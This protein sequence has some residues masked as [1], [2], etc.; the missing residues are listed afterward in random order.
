MAISRIAIK[1]P[2][3]DTPTIALNSTGTYVLSV[4][5]ANTSASQTTKVDVWVAPLDSEEESD[6]GYISKNAP[7]EPGNSLE[8]FRFA[9]VPDDVLYVKSDNGFA[10]FSVVG[11]SQ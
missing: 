7:I 2:A 5:M 1:N 11:I 9:L 4:I 10:S 6:W 3:A 8:T